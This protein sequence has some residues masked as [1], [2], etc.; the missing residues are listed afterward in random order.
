MT[1]TQQHRFEVWASTML[2]LT[3]SV[4]LVVDFLLA[5]GYFASSHSPKGYFTL[6]VA[7]PFLLYL[8]Y[9]IRKGV[10]GA[11]KLFLVLYAL[12]LLELLQGG[13]ALASYDTPLEVAN[14]LVQHGL[15]VGACLLLLLSMRTP[16]GASATELLR[17]GCFTGLSDSDLS[18]HLHPFKSWL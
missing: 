1:I 4:S 11:K 5:C 10:S 13:L 17:S 9:Q 18:N 7:N 14:L 2:Y 3:F 15:Q 6:Y 12:V 16:G 8:Y